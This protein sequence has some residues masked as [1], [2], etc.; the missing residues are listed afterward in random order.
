MKNNYKIIVKVDLDNAVRDLSVHVISTTY[1]TNQSFVLLT[2]APSLFLSKRDE[3]WALLQLGTCPEMRTQ[4]EK[5]TSSSVR[6]LL[7]LL[8]AAEFY[9]SCSSLMTGM[10]FFKQARVVGG[11]GLVCL[12]V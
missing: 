2:F 6:F 5:C 4:P 8:P 1:K 3:I 12:F 10:L 7:F 9:T 11:R